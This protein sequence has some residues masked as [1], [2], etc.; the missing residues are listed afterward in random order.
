MMWVWGSY[1]GRFGI[2]RRLWGVVTVLGMH[3]SRHRFSVSPKRRKHRNHE[4]HSHLDSK[5]SILCTPAAQAPIWRL[6]VVVSKHPRRSIHLQTLTRSESQ[7]ARAR[8]RSKGGP[9]VLRFSSRCGTQGAAQHSLG[10]FSEVEQRFH[11]AAYQRAQ[12][13]R[14]RSLPL[15][16]YICVCLC[17][18]SF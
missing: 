4:R 1:S 10:S 14:M 8:V 12:F 9:C 2:I 3:S 18:R 11:F 17:V 5:H 16:S 13:P 7:S 6:W 15:Q